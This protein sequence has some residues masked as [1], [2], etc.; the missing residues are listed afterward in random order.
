[1]C[2]A[3]EENERIYNYSCFI[4]LLKSIIIFCLEEKEKQITSKVFFSINP[5]NDKTFWTPEHVFV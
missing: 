4:K 2:Y 1:M 5:W 3:K